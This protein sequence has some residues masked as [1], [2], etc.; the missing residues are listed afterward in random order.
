M[1][2]AIAAVGATAAGFAAVVGLHTASS[3]SGKTLLKT[4][5]PSGGSAR[6]TGGSSQSGSKSP[7]GPAAGSTTPSPPT[8][9]GPAGGATGS[10]VG[11][12]EQY[13]YG[14]L[15]VKVTVSG[16]KITDVSLANLRV[17]ESYSQMIAQQVVP[18]LRQEV[19]AANSARV[20]GVSGAT[21]TSE[22]YLM[23]TQS[24]LDKLHA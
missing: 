17:A 4:A 19:L 20:N 21:Y 14:I 7:S 24:A 5:A 16:G 18:M 12:S 11:A 13:G 1:N 22:A 6:S 10:A 3:A 8:T 2:R 9:A 15:S 23:S